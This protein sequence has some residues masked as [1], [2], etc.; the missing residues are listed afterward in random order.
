MPTMLATTKIN[1]KK[2]INKILMYF[3]T[4]FDYLSIITKVR[5]D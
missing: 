2:H 5:Q 1:T 4:T 3:S